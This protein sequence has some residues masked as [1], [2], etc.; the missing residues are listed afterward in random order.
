MTVPTVMRKAI[1][2]V[3]PV[4]AAG[5][6]ASTF[7]AAPFADWPYTMV[8]KLN[9]SATGANVANPV[10]DFPVLVRLDAGNFDFDQAKSDGSDVRFTRQAAGGDP[11]ELPMQIERWSKSG[12]V[13]EIWVRVD[14]IEGNDDGQAI[15]MRWGNPS[16][17]ASAVGP[18]F[19][20]DNGFRAV[21]HIA[22]S[23]GEASGGFK[24]ATPNGFNAT[25]KG[26]MPANSPTG[27]RIGNAQWFDGLTDYIDLPS[28][29]NTPAA[30][31]S[32]WY[33]MDANNKPNAGLLSNGQWS[34]GVV[35]FKQN[36]AI[37]TVDPNS[38]T[39][40]TKTGQATGTWYQAT[41]TFSRNGAVGLYVNGALVATGTAPDHDWVGSNLELGHE[42]TN[43]SSG[44][45]YFNGV[46]DEARVETVVRS[47]DWI[48]LCYENQKSSQKLVQFIAIPFAHAGGTIY[49][50]V[51]MNGYQLTNI[52]AVTTKHWR[53]PAPDYVFAPGYDLPSIS[54]TRSYIRAHGHL[55]G[56]P[57]AS[58]MSASGM[59]LGTMNLLMLKQMEHMHLYLIDQDARVRALEEQKA[60]KK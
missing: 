15:V 57:S 1:R 16:A 53:I 18:V 4:L 3:F 34:S 25:G 54:E 51:D 7:A 46:I 2:L 60:G 29:P 27:G 41:Y 52:G 58:E 50:D 23:P 47:A 43:Y 11:V 6:L 21:W 24:D 28:L 30:T 44:N 36:N 20:S 38:G 22:E 26:G 19:A 59:E 33:N 9:T 17:S 8:L 45:R 39:S 42:Y 56:I 5:L 12:Q 35:H 48:K 37:L 40:A 31:V 49:G 13:A 32:V 14:V 10:T 55:P